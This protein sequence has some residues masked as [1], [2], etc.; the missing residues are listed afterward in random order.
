MNM[1]WLI[2]A[3][4]FA[5]VSASAAQAADVIVPR[6]PAPIA[7]VI[8][9]PAFSWTGFYLGGQIGSFSSKTK[10]DIF[11]QGKW[12][13]ANKDLLPKLSGFMGGFYA[14]SNVDLGNGLVL[15]VDTD[16][17]WSDK[18]D[19]KM[20]RAYNI[21]EADIPYIKRILT[22][23]GIQ[24]S[25][26]DIQKDD[27]RASSFTF[28]EKWAG[29]TRMRVGF[30]A[31]RIMPYIAGGIAYTQLQD[32]ASISVTKSD[33]GKVIASGNLSDEKK[34]LVGYTLGAGVDFS[35]TNHVIVRAEYRYSDFG[36]KKF[37]KDKN[38]VSYKTN[39]FRVG[40]AYK[41]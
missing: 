14:G 11:S 21:N 24:I 28:K 12:I 6:D 1:K 20:G 29:A 38:D 39:D 16:I 8:V 2:T 23:A 15:G 41:F 9:A 27:K 7:P 3:S 33:T 19:T 35:M 40:V 10:M 17:V 4:A 26:D 25:D 31:N 37:A 32:I 34:S 22:D 36:K 13:S 30:A 18:S 5:L